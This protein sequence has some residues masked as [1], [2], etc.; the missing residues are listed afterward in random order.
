LN[1][2]QPLPI[3]L[4]INVTVMTRYQADMDQILSHLLPYI[5]P[6]FVVSWR[7]PSRP[8]FEIRSNVYWNGAA[9]IQYPTDLNSN[10]VARVI[11]DLSFV[12]KGWIFQAL[13]KDVIGSI[14]T[15]QSTY[16]ISN[17]VDYLESYE[18]YKL[19]STSSSENFDLL[20]H[21]G[22]PPQ[23][24]VIEP[25]YT[26]VGKNKQFFVFGSGFTQLRNVYLSVAPL[27]EQSTFQNPFSAISSLSADYPGFFAVKLPTN[28]WS[29]N[30][31]NFMSFVMPSATIPGRIDLILENT[32]GWDSLINNVRINS[33]DP[34]AT[35][36]TLSTI[37]FEPYQ[38][39][40]LSGVEIL[41]RIE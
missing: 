12:F 3:D 30:Y 4:T 2:K 23:P 13:P 31:D 39:P 33:F 20:F 7:T 24:K 36:P 25:S 26:H 17:N 28:K 18:Q 38:L 16:A 15:I 27:N 41:P 9:N 10:Q 5:N 34:F 37:N 32:G 40:F 22:T 6:Y 14:Y 11:A 1:E 29:T 21:K 8:D 19:D 35:L